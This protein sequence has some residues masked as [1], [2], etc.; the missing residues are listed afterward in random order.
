MKWNEN[1]T[2][3]KNVYKNKKGLFKIKKIWLVSKNKI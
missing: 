2:E 3:T 1:K